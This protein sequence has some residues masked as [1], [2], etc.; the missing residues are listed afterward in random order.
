MARL[1][2]SRT[3]LSPFHRKTSPSPQSSGVTV[4]SARL[5]LLGCRGERDRARVGDGSQGGSLQVRG[6]IFT[7]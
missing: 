1:R 2:S 5:C 6:G 4:S 7:V 3:C